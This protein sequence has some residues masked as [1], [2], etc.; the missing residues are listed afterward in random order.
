MRVLSFVI[1]F[2]SGRAIRSF[3]QRSEVRWLSRVV[4]VVALILLASY[5]IPNVVT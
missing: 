4:R 2:F 1:E 3:A 5:L